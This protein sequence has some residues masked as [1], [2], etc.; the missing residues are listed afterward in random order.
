MINI[1]KYHPNELRY[2]NFLLSSSRYQS[3]L[4][5]P[6]SI[7]PAEDAYIAKK[8]EYPS[9]HL[10]LGGR[11][12]IPG[13]FEKGE[14]LPLCV[15]TWN[16]LNSDY[17]HHL[18]RPSWIEGYYATLDKIPSL[19][20]PGLSKRE[21]ACIH[22]IQKLMSSGSRSLDVLWI[23]ECASQMFKTLDKI[24]TLASNR[25]KIVIFKSE[26][27]ALPGNKQI[28]NHVVTLIRCSTGL[29]ITNVFSKPLWQRKYTSPE[30]KTL[31]NP[32]GVEKIGMDIWRQALFVEAESTSLLG[33]KEKIV[34]A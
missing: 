21:E 11:V 31:E 7:T 27:A 9:D 32:K 4:K 10:A 15:G 18:T 25:D 26:N 19:E 2:A 23:Q 13:K 6:I 1:C 8:W 5:E 30:T 34:I 22:K 16:K 24:S 20:Y 12:S 17:I 3:H 28:N 29:S 33:K 14:T